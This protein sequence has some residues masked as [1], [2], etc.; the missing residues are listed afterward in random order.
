MKLKELRDR[1]NSIDDQILKL[2][3]ERAEISQK[4]GSIKADA[5]TEIYVPHREYEILNRL[6][7]QNLGIY[8]ED[9]IDKIWAEIF[10]ASRAV[11]TPNRVAFLGP[12]GSF[13][14]TASLSF[15]GPSA[16]MIPITPQSDIFTEVEIGRADFGVVAMENSVHGTVRDVLERFL[17]TSLNICAE[18]YQPIRHHLISKSDFAEIQCIYS[19]RQSFA[20]C[21]L[22]LNKFMK[23]VEQ[24]EVVSTSDA[25]QRAADEPN[26]A[27]I[28]SKLA[29]EIYEVP[30][31]A[32][33]IMDEPKNTTRFLV[34][35]DQIVGKSGH[36]RTSIFFAIKDKVGALY[37][38]LGVFNKHQRNLSYIES[39]PSRTKPWEY[40][41][42]ADID[43]HVD[44][45]D[46]HSVLEHLEDLCRD[47]KILGSYP[48]GTE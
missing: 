30:V 35:G 48:R 14:H 10:A 4:I 31:V 34:I 26:T 6:K 20:Q 13:G 40:I 19:H 5:G 47:V 45:D 16:Q 9:A 15:F 17:H 32:D 39:L 7:T 21:R 18:I 22:W 1:I 3:H 28:A 44:D 2:L 29:S 33:S 38:V 12:S 8:P 43:G 25:A 11:Q 42:Y 24:V 23:S 36:D 37:E 41:F 46:V 27:A